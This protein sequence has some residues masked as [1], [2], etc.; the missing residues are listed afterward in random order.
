MPGTAAEFLLVLLLRGATSSDGPPRCS[1]LSTG[2]WMSCPMRRRRWSRGYCRDCTQP[3][4]N[5]AAQPDIRPAE[6]RLFP[7]LRDL[8]SAETE[9]CQ[10]RIGVLAQGR[11]RS[12][13]SG[14]SGNDRRW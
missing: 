10:Y 14:V 4:P 6:L 7:Q 2:V 3:E 13:R 12:H 9:F 8:L 1:S 11:Y 5:K